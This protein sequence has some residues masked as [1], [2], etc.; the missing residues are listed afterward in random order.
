MAK[1]KHTPTADQDLVQISTFIAKDNTTAAFRWLDEMQQVC[2]LLA[3]QPGIGQ[4]M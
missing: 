1:A 4:L 2:D 3:V